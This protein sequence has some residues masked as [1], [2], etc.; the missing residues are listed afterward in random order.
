MERLT[1]VYNSKRSSTLDLTED[2]DLQNVLKNNIA[3]HVKY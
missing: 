3:F 2:E 1:K